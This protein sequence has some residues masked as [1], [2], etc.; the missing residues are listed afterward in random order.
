MRIVG[1]FITG[2]SSTGKTFL[3]NALKARLRDMGILTYHISEVARTVMREQGF[4]R[5]DV[6]TISYV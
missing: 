3:C 5:K 2:P 1:I 6:G 4:T